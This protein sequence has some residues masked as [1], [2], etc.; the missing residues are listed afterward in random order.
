MNLAQN[1]PTPDPS[2]EGNRP[3]GVAPLL[4]G[5]GGG[6]M[7]PMHAQ[8][9]RGLC[10]NQSS[11]IRMTNAEIRGNTEIRMTKTAELA[12]SPFGFWISF[13]ICHLSFAIGSWS[14]G[15]FNSTGSK[16]R[17]IGHIGQSCMVVFS[18]PVLRLP[19]SHSAAQPVKARSEPKERRAQSIHRFLAQRSARLPRRL[20]GFSVLKL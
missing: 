8:K 5:A 3:A 10:M 13:V 16:T 4:G 12:G 1:Q 6:F 2:R 11:Q 15:M 18:G 14:Q 17:C 7:V 20:D 19:E 9:R